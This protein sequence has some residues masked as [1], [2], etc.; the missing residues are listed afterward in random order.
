ML[1]RLAQALR[2]A[3]LLLPGFLLYTG[4]T[5]IG[6]ELLYGG[7]GG[8]SDGTSI[9]D[10][11]LLIVD[12]VTAA[13]TVIGHPT[14][15]PRLTGIA[16][17]SAGALFASTLP[18]GGFPPPPPRLTS[19]LITLD[20]STGALLSTIGPIRDGPG[21]PPMSVSDIAFQPVTGR[22]FGIRSSVDGLGS[23]G[24]LYTIDTATGVATT[25]GQTGA[26][27]ATIAFAPDGTLYEVT[28][29][30][31]DGPV[32]P[33]IR[34][35]NPSNGAV[36]TEVPTSEFFGALA[37][38]SD[39]ALFGSTGDDHE[40]FTINPATGAVSETGDTGRNYVGALAF[41]R[42]S[43]GPCVP[44]DHT[45]CLNN[46]RFSL[47]ALWRTGEGLTGQGTGVKLTNDSGYFWF[48]GAANIELVTKVLNACDPFHYYWVFAAGLTDVEVTLFV[49]DTNTGTLRTYVNPLHVPFA[50]VQDTTAFAT[51]P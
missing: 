26:F 13:V 7:N 51:C 25:V 16:F 32:N 42:L 10:G 21:G 23:Q 19:T 29:A 34:T 22:L 28:A 4:D 12:Q 17:D 2:S 31:L 40:I 20:A 6:Q 15:V 30:L 1:K 27:F 43:S 50:P 49:T 36:L 44:S 8:H 47:F 38:R 46:G 3:V 18:A 14:G 33:K 41:H 45:L 37:V 11:S 24:G 35:L 5:A 48:F 9:N 39:G